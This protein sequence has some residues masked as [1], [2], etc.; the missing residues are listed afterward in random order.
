VSDPNDIAATAIETAPASRGLRYFGWMRTRKGLMV[1]FTEAHPSSV[2]F[3]DPKSIES[4]KVA[5]ASG[6][7]HLKCD[8]NT[9]AEFDDANQADAAVRQLFAIVKSS[10]APSFMEPK[11]STTARTKYAGYAASALVGV[12]LVAAIVIGVPRG[13]HAPADQPVTAS[14]APSAAFI[15][16]P[17][18]VAM[19]ELPQTASVSA[20]VEVAIPQEILDALTR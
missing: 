11:Q 6:K 8:G 3:I 15:P 1:C 2:I 4:I 14:A 17:N 13:H 5:G 7:F 19:P 20:P 12:A 18:A 16:V 10:A 9:V